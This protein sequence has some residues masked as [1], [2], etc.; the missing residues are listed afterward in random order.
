MI[1]EWYKTNGYHFLTLSDHNTIAEGTKWIG[2]TNE[3]R[4]TAFNK[5]QAR[6]GNHFDQ[7]TEEDLHEVRLKT[8]EE[9]APLFNEPGKFLLM[10]GEE[11]SDRHM[12]APIHL[13]AI[14]LREHIEPRGGTSVVD[15]MQ[16]NVDA[17]LEQRKRTRQPMFAHINH[18]NFRWA[19]TAE[20]LMHVR[21]EKFFE[22]YNGHPHVHNDGDQ[23]HAST[24][25]MWDIIL[26]RRL[27][28]LNL[29]VMYG[30]AT[31][32]SH[33]YHVNGFGENTPGQGWIMVRARRLT[34]KHIIE[35]MEAGDFYGSSGVRLKDVQRGRKSYRIEIDPEP[36]VEYMTIFI[37]TRKGYSNANEPI[38][39]NSGTPLRVTH[40]YTDDVGQ[41]LTISFGTNPVYQLR[42]DEIYVRAKVISTKRRFDESTPAAKQKVGS[43]EEFESAWCQPL[44]TGIK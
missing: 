40:R 39:A 37:G 7:R 33:R 8:F 16:R 12:T 11:L 3:S 20:E 35:A 32:D 22:V 25:K 24:E 17:V 21:N 44:V 13:G 18:P 41:L 9:Y 34:D 30:I 4:K 36:G 10:R 23:T 6:W 1:I 5:Y 43:V 26:T 28:E 42:G 38:R 14:N 2:I 19:I 27:A 29:P 31:D 15:V